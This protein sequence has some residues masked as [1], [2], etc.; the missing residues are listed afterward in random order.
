M[1]ESTATMLAFLNAQPIRR[2]ST[3]S[4]DSQKNLESPRPA[5][6]MTKRIIDR[7][8]LPLHRTSN[9][10]LQF[11]N[12][13]KQMLAPAPARRGMGWFEHY[14]ERCIT[15]SRFREKDDLLLRSP[16]DEATIKM[17]ERQGGTYVGS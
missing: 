1:P 7:K 6:L 17:A 11:L 2:R 9:A 15:L 10:N 8:S 5:S 3:P 13:S 12:R 4:N 14:A 16:C